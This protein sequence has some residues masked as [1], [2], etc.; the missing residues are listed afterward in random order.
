[1]RGILKCCMLAAGGFMLGRTFAK[2]QAG[3]AVKDS[4]TFTRER[5]QFD[6]MI[7]E[8]IFWPEKDASEVLSGLKGIV[9][10]YGM[11]SMAD[12]CDLATISNLEY[13]TT[14]YGWTDLNSAMVVPVKYG[15]KIQLP[16]IQPIK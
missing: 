8:I 6:K 1:M 11:A 2:Y 4:F 15:Y 14:K 10:R 16:S 13:R 7:D 9:E 12:F 3:Q 5:E